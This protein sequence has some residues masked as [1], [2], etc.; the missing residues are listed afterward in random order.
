MGYSP[1]SDWP[2]EVIL[3][4]VGEAEQRIY[5]IYQR[6]PGEDVEQ[7]PQREEGP[8]GDCVF[9][10]LPLDKH[11]G[12]AHEGADDRS[13]HKGEDDPGNAAEGA[14][15]GEELYVTAAHAFSFSHHFV[16]SGNGIE[17]A[18]AQ[19]H[20]E[21]RLENCRQGAEGDQ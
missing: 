18:A 5:C 2:E 8:E 20:A 6:V 9:C 1:L 12:K 17:D 13:G 16:E 19:E 4:P 21:E 3:A 11:Q 15:H 7:R 10:A 14:Y